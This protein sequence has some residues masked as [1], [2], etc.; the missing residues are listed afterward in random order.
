MRK[1]SDRYSFLK[2]W[3]KRWERL[4]RH[5]LGVVFKKA[6]NPFPPSGIV[7]WLADT[8]IYLLD[9]LLVPEIYQGI[10]KLMDKNIRSLTEEE[11]DLARSIYKDTIR[12][13]AV[14]MNP[15]DRLLT[16]NVAIAFVS[17]NIINYKH[18]I[19]K[20]VFIHELMHIW[21][22]QHFGSI[23]IAR[24]LKAQRSREGYDYGGVESLYDAMISGKKLTSYNF[25]Q[26]AEM[27]EDYY[28]H[29]C[30][31]KNL[32]PMVAQTYEYFTGQIHE[33]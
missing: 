19:R 14:R 7:E 6:S 29:Q 33:V 23:Y 20:E 32:H 5:F 15:N 21:Q 24:A 2:D 22:Y 31:N 25:E 28:R 30:L 10:F 12:Y 16:K 18:Q 13:E 3:L 11:I 17:F 26:Q 27:M 9:V 8:S 4:F 1:Q